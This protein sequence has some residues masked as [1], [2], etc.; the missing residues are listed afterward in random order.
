[1]AYWNIGID[2]SGMFTY[3][4]AK[5]KRSFVCA[6]ISQESSDALEEKFAKLF[7]RM[8]GREHKNACELL[9]Y[10]HAMERSDEEKTAI[11]DSLKNDVCKVVMSKGRPLVLC[12]PQHWWISAV[13]SVLQRIISLDEIKTG[14]TLEIYLA[15]RWINVIGLPVEKY[16]KTLEEKT[17]DWLR[18]HENLQGDLLRWLKSIDKKVLNIYLYC[19]PAKKSGSVTLADQAVGMIW[20]NRQ[21]LLMDKVCYA[22]CADYYEMFNMAPPKPAT[23]KTDA[24][25]KT[26]LGNT[27]EDAC[28]NFMDESNYLTA[29]QFWL[30]AFFAKENIPFKMF[31]DI[32]NGAFADGYAYTEAWRIV[33]DTCEYALDNR[34]DDPQLIERVFKLEPELQNEYARI[35]KLK[36]EKKL[37]YDIDIHLLTDIWRVL[38][39]VASHRG[40]VTCPVLDYVDRF[41]EAGGQEIGSTL[42][43]WKFYLQTKLIGAQIPFNGYDFASV[44]ERMEPL[45]DCHEKLCGLPFPFENATVDDE[46]AALLG[47]CGQTAAFQENLDDAINFFEDDYANS[48][49]A[50]K[51]MPASFMVTVLHRQQNFESACEWFKKQTGGI[52]FEYFG[53]TLSSTSDLWQ[54]VNYFKILVMAQMQEKP[55][56]PHIPD[57]ESWNIQNSYPWPLALK[58]AAF[59]LMLSG[60][61]ERGVELLE[62][63]HRLLRKGG[64]A[65]K[66]LSLPI[67]QML[68]CVTE[69][70][71]YET[72]YKELLEK[73][74]GS[75]ET[76]RAFV[77]NRS[78]SFTLDKDKDPW[79]AAMILPFNYA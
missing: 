79:D 75:C 6:A 28:K 39:K 23:Q 73:L 22:E 56:E 42:D 51:P 50:C 3:Y 66:T 52:P 10:F 62:S 1:M 17:A 45:L 34:G 72:T 31:S 65:I 68:Y 57:L 63:A 35:D 24:E 38:V 46:L 19:E 58:W 25:E 69:D 60:Q 21:G 61:G 9:N 8:N 30:R 33:L 67:L 11:F 15:T 47:T 4:N 29:L 76:F 70:E 64:F 18:Y 43:R 40:D 59:S 12:N 54:M 13:M 78:D 7:Y 32:M 20:L 2:E 5:G 48:S 14:D 26:P 27:N 53:K 16:E 55:V 71:Q 49:E 77:E 44:T 36:S 37:G 74:T 41:W